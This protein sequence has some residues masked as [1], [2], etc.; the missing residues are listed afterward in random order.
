M[1]TPG[2]SWTQRSVVPRLVAVPFDA[3]RFQYASAVDAGL[4]PRSLLASAASERVIDALE[5]FMLGPIARRR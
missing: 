2:P 4:F 3:L 5:K 1:G